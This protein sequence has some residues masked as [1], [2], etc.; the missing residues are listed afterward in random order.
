MLSF[1]TPHL[2]SYLTQIS[3]LDLAPDT[4]QFV[5]SPPV[6]YINCGCCVNFFQ[7]SAISQLAD[8]KKRLIKEV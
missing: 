2:V 5:A 8:L 1:G 7:K 3:D 4:E 6:R